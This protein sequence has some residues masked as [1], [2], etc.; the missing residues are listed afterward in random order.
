[1][2]YNT[3]SISLSKCGKY[4]LIYDVLEFYP[5][6]VSGEESNGYIT[7]NV[8]GDGLFPDIWHNL[9]STT[10]NN[11][12]WLKLETHRYGYSPKPYT[13]GVQHYSLFKAILNDEIEDIVDEYG[14]KLHKAVVTDTT[15]EGVYNPDGSD[16]E[17]H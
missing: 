14:R 10:G 8:S 2:V 11:K 12:A 15:L 5:H 17:F 3:L 9:C 7:V 6:G 13:P 4:T 16:F 1:M